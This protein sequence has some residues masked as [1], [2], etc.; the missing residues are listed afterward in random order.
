MRYFDHELA[1]RDQEVLD[2]HLHSCRGCR[3]LR[4]D[5][6]G[7]LNTLEN[8]V[9][10]EPDA[11]L[12]KQVLDRIMSMPAGPKG[13][14]DTL[15]KVAYGTLAGLAALFLLILALSFQSMGYVDLMMAARDYAYW[16]SAFLVNLQIAYEIV[17]GLFPVDVVEASREIL[18]V[19]VLAVF[20][21]LL[22]A[23]KTALARSAAEN[24]DMP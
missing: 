6:T 24:P 11:D 8:A 16:S 19:S 14:R 10:M 23:V 17:S 5:L 1:R 20:V 9:P 12:E 3:A 22:V 21:L 13:D 7:I 15:P 2:Q 4:Q 18:A